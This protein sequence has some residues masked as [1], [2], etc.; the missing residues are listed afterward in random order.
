MA[1][2]G[3]CITSHSASVDTTGCDAFAWRS[4]D[5]P[6]RLMYR[7]F[8]HERGVDGNHL[9]QKDANIYKDG[10]DPDVG[11]ENMLVLLQVGHEIGCCLDHCFRLS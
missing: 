1:L 2:L 8:V 7:L 5:T 6:Q 11:D 9:G 3:A 10:D 4:Y